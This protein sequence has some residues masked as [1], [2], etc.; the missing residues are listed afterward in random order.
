MTQESKQ[1][2]KEQATKILYDAFHVPAPSDLQE[3]IGKQVK[4]MDGETVTIEKI[5]GSAIKPSRFEING[6]HHIVMLDFYGQINGEEIPQEEIDAF[7]EVEFHVETIGA[8][9]GKKEIH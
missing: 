4:C 2:P 9:N 5:V 3:Y 6:K 7:D 1:L 8:Q